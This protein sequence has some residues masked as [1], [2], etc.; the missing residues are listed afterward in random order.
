MSLDNSRGRH[1][2]DHVDR[3]QLVEFWWR[4]LRCRRSK[5]WEP[6]STDMEDK[7]GQL[8]TLGIRPLLNMLSVN[9]RKLLA[10]EYYS[11]KGDRS[12]KGCLAASSSQLFI[13]I[14]T[15]S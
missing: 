12:V 6:V 11:R 10:I 1:F 15:I 8:L 5:I 2:F 13:I 4:S 7:Q 3:N 9:K 14:H